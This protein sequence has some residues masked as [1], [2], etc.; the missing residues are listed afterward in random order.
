MEIECSI[1]TEFDEFGSLVLGI[2][3]NAPDG[4]TIRYCYPWDGPR[5]LFIQGE[6]LAPIEPI[7]GVEV[8]FRL[9]HGRKAISDVQSWRFEGEANILPRTMIPRTQN[10]DF[11]AYDWGAR[12]RAVC[13]LAK[14]RTPSLILFGDSITHFWGGDPIDPPKLDYLRM[15]PDA[16]D[17]C[18]G[19]WSHVNMG[20]ANDRI[21]NML[22]R[23]LHGELEHVDPRAFCCLL[24]GTNNFTVNTNEEMTM[25]IEHLCHTILQKLPK[26]KI[27]LQG[28][29][30][31]GDVGSDVRE[32]MDALNDE[33]SRLPLIDGK[34]VIYHNTGRCLLFPDGTI[35]EGV[36][37]DGIHPSKEGYERIAKELSPVLDLFYGG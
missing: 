37:R 9:F 36:S 19:A 3:K 11:R 23:V 24:I 17:E 7:P 12:H 15:A 28:I 5:L 18:M 32:R 34:R 14:E 35:R 27:L 25:G 26:G 13:S 16:W 33:W 8:R 22:W 6:Y 29:Y 20:F 2:P 31:R 30:P 4:A 1:S 10:R 21:E